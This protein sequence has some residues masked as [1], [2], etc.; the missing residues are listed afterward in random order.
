VNTDPRE[1]AAAMLFDL[2]GTLLDT[3][4]DMIGAL[5]LVLGE[6]GRAPL[7][8]DVVRSSVSHGAVRLVSVGFPDAQGEEFERL[9]QRFLRVYSENLADGTRLFDGL[10]AVLGHLESS[11][12]PWGVVT[13]KPGWLTDPLMQRLGLASRAACVVSGDTVAERKPHPLPL[14]HAA[15]IAGVEP[16][17]CV[18]VGDA[19]RDIVAGR[20]AGMQTVAA[21]YGY[22]G[23]DDSPA[24]W[25]PHG[26]VERP[27]Q[28][29][30]WL[31]LRL[32]QTA[33]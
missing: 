12:V 3:A 21:A 7:A 6:E 33:T 8:F 19:E 9:R 11:G 28:V 18:Y 13:N 26:I 5:N 10:E 20:A 2:D 4:P 31:T 25:N 32:P 27:E 1:R 17:R 22:L 15:K 14:L 30:D 29:L 24:A 23:P 16:T